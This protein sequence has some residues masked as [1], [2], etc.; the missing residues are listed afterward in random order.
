MK[1]TYKFD[2]DLNEANFILTFSFE[3]HT[4]TLSNLSRKEYNQLFVIQNML[5]SMGSGDSRTDSDLIFK[6]LICLALRVKGIS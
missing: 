1:Y 2:K 3:E 5:P 4:S 6:D